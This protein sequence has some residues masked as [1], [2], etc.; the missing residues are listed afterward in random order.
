MQENRQ[1]MVL[2]RW[3]YK[4]RGRKGPVPKPAWAGPAQSSRSPVIGFLL[5]CQLEA[6]HPGRQGHPHGDQK[7]YVSVM[8]SDKMTRG[9]LCL[10]N[11]HSTMQSH[12]QLLIWM[13]WGG[14]IRRGEGVRDSRQSL[15]PL[16]KLYERLH[17]TVIFN[18]C[19]SLWDGDLWRLSKSRKSKQCILFEI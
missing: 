5:E 16:I 7:S 3:R 14:P 15:R 1:G 19:S 6:Q 17:L 13:M 9:S 8:G 12:L 10:Q 18:S 11:H 4:M 2:P